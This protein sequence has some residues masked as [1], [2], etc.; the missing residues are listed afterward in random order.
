MH[1]KC[2]IQRNRM[3]A[4]EMA[5]WVEVVTIKPRNLSS[6][7]GGGAMKGESRLLE[8]VFRL[9]HTC[10]G[11]GYVHMCVPKHTCVYTQRNTETHK[12]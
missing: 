3:Q 12:T 11:N 7:P 4:G 2:G 8:A 10:Q 5:P 1:T 6:R 9:P